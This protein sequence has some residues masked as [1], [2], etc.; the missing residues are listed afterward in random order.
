M[1]AKRAALRELQVAMQH[2]QQAALTKQQAH[3]TKATAG[4]QTAEQDRAM[5]TSLTTE[6]HSRTIVR[7]TE[8]LLSRTGSQV[9]TRDLGCHVLG[10]E[11]EDAHR[12]ATDSVSTVIAM[13]RMPTTSVESQTWNASCAICFD[14]SHPS[15]DG[16]QTE[17]FETVGTRSVAQTSQRARSNFEHESVT[18][19]LECDRIE[20]LGLVLEDLLAKKRQYE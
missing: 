16:M 6:H 7:K 2:Q 10:P 9:W 19:H 20:D 17:L 15:R 4:A 14:T 8:T 1:E 12:S 13:A 5:E 18:V 3:V 11:T